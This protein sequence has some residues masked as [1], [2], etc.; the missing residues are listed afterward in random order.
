MLARIA[1]LLFVFQSS[2]ALPSLVASSVPNDLNT[3][4]GKHVTD[5]NL[6]S[7]D[8]VEALIRVSNDFKIPMGIAWVNTPA[9]RAMQPL[10]WKKAT[11]QEIIEA[12]VKKHFGYQVQVKNGVVHVSPSALIPDRE[13]FLK[14]KIE[15]FKVHNTEIEVAS[16]KLRSF[17]MVRKG[18]YQISIGSTGDSQVSLVLENS[19]VEDILDGLVAASNRK[20]WVVAFSDDTGLTPRGFRRTRSLWTDKPIP[21]AEQPVW[22]LMRWGDPM[23]PAV[24]AAKQQN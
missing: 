2:W 24:V 9:E 10:A 3:Q 17:L 22:Q 15:A 6:G 23:P 18:N 8:F 1:L 14:L 20:I 5:Y 7:L 11:V 13:N 12:I 4:L 21:D 19:T 16:W